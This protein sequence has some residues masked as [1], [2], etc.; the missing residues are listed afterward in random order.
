MSFE[1]GDDHRRNNGTACLYVNKTRYIDRAWNENA[2]STIAN[3]N[4]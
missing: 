2:S 1:N 4:Y 3:D